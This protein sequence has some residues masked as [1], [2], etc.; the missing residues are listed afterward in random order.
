[1]KKRVYSILLLVISLLF[2]AIILI[3]QNLSEIHYEPKEIEEVVKEKR[4]SIAM[5]GDA[6]LHNSVYDDA[7]NGD[8]TYNFKPM[9][10]DIKEL[11]QDYDLKYYN[12]ETIIGGKKLG[13]SNYPRFNSP[14]E[15]GLDLVDAGFNLISLANNHTMDKNEQGILY[16]NQ[17]W[18]EQDVITA[19][20]YSDAESR[21][22]IPVHE[23]NDIKYAFLSYTIGTNGIPVPAGKEYLVSIY[24]D[25]Q[26]EQDILKIKDQVDVIIVA[27]H[28]GVEY[29]HVP[30]N[31][32][33][34]IVKHLSKLGV[35]LI[36]GAHPHVIQP[37]DMYDN[38]L[39]IYSLGNF[40]SGQKILGLE[41]IIGLFVGVDIVV[42]DGV[43]S[44]ENLQY[45][46]LYTYC[47]SSYKQFKVIPFSK[48]TDEYLSGYQQINEKYRN[49]VE[50]EVTYD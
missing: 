32:Q 27:M 25:E 38:T 7:S 11:I 8:G 9:F 4:L 22:N 29:S 10:T 31:Q 28:W 23:I 45:E 20:T 12:Q 44:F 30:N 47:N 1:M 34:H 36:I 24:S 16:S 41:K 37:I 17:F 3:P 33:K 18:S 42:N 5:V 26:A 15:I 21:E 19:G 6:L 48:L 50:Q 43:V 14:D 13:L 35:S 49:I 39:V 2:I 40:I 46:L